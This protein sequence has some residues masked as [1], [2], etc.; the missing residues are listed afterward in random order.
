MLAVLVGSVTDVVS[1]VVVTDAH[2]VAA[3]TADSVTQGSVTFA[4]DVGVDD[5]PGWN[6]IRALPITA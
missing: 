3:F 4:W 6:I 2:A 5:W 1:A